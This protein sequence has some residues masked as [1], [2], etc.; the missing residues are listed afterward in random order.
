M[1]KICVLENKMENGMI[2]KTGDILMIDKKGLIKIIQDNSDKNSARIDGDLIKMINCFYGRLSVKQMN[3]I[4]E[5]V[6]YITR[7]NNEYR[8]YKGFKDI[9]IM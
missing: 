7:N 8:K 1:E 6:K 9:Q 5:K 4:M 2:E 3:W